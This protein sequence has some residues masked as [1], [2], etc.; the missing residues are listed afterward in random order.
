MAGS[1]DLTNFKGDIW[2][3]TSLGIL[4]G[5]SISRKETLNF[6]PTGVSLSHTDKSR[7]ILC[8]CWEH[9]GSKDQLYAGLRNG[10]VQCFDCNKNYFTAECKLTDGRGH[11][12]GLAKHEKLI[13]H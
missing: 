8:M 2:V 5:V 6:L 9:G 3:G 7:D 12:V 4:K 11:F 13:N 10:L 1:G